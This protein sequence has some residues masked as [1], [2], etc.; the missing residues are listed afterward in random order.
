MQPEK[1]QHRSNIKK[2][3]EWSTTLYGFY[4]SILS[5]W[6]IEGPVLVSF[7]FEFKIP[8][9]SII[10]E[11]NFYLEQDYHNYFSWLKFLFSY[12]P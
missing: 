4:V 1:T 2:S 12:F 8:F 7:R 5:H 3:K 9:S 10:Q 6:K 11:W